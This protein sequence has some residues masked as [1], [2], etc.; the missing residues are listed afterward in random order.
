MDKLRHHIK[1]IAVVIFLPIC[2]VEQA[3]SQKNI[4]VRTHQKISETEGV[5]N[6]TL[7]DIDQFGVSL[8]TIGDLNKDGIVDLIVGANMDDDGGTNFG[9]VWILFMEA[10]GTVKSNQK[11]SD[12]QGNF[13]EGL[14][15][16]DLFGS[17]VS[18][19]GDL[20]GDSITDIA[21]SVLK[22][23]DGGT[24]RGAVFILFLN[25]DGTVKSY[26]KISS[27]QGG[28]AGDLGDEDFFGSSLTKIADLNGDTIPDLVVGARG[29]DDGATDQGGL[30]ILYL[31][32]NG[33]VKNHSKISGLKGNFTGTLD[34]D[35]QFGYSVESL[36]DLD[37][38]GVGDIAVGSINND[39][40]GSNR[41]A[42][43]ILFLNSNG[44]VKSHQ[45]IS[46]TT[47]NFTSKLADGDQFGSAITNIGDINGDNI[48]DI[49]VSATLHD[50]TGDN[51]GAVWILLLNTD[52]TVKED[53]EISSSQGNFV[54]N[55][56]SEDKFGSSLTPLGDLDNDGL[57]DMA[58]GCFHDDD[59]GLDK[60]AIYLLFLRDS[61]ICNTTASFIESAN[62]ICQGQTVDFT[63]TSFADSYIWQ[64]ND[65][66]FSNET[67]IAKTFNSTGIYIIK[68]I[69][70]KE[71]CLDTTEITI[72]VQTNPVSLFNI[73]DS[74]YCTTSPITLNS[75]STNNSNITWLID[76]VNIADT[77]DT[78][79]T[80]SNSGNYTISLI[81]G[82][83]ACSDTSEKSITIIESAVSSF[84]II[85]T[86]VC[87]DEIISISNNSSGSSNYQWFINN[88]KVSDSLNPKISNADS[89]LY[90]IQLISSNS[91]CADTSNKDISI[92]QS[93]NITVSN[94]S[95]ICI[96]DLVALIASGATSYSWSPS[97][98][99]PLPDSAIT[100][101]YPDTTTRYQVIL[102]RGECSSDTQYVTITVDNYPDFDLGE[103]IEGLGGEEI[104]LSASDG[105]T[106]I[107]SPTNYLNDPNIANPIA[108]PLAPITYTVSVTNQTGCTT[109]DSIFIDIKTD[110]FI[111]NFFSPNEDGENDNFKIYGSGISEIELQ[112]FNRLGQMV[113][114]TTD[115]NE[116]QNNGWNGSYNGT[117]QPD[118]VYI[119]KIY[120]T[121]Y[122]ETELSYQRKNV[123][124]FTLLR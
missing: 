82:I 34:A 24:D 107:W 115:I 5:F 39:D 98:N 25:Q 6:G 83:S 77:S 28:F 85:D 73:S 54:G 29:D 87:T 99:L 53:F 50:D 10:D 59:G 100:G 116:A 96:G 33:T 106:Y 112:I 7:D 88:T 71:G 32:T 105:E 43:W 30:W 70:E 121:F 124:T 123:G 55:L 113:F 65:S 9:A 67:S 47:G 111:P 79:I 12:I 101:A 45:K 38:D 40:G 91:A 89:G 78:V 48:T 119:W 114:I 19:L 18:N 57:L 31:D 117:Q 120:G 61:I 68:L 23:D 63:N 58:V 26:K 44:T 80:I 103:D 76:N 37:N 13:N 1:L 36:G 81:A 14:N 52:G 2:L 16:N 60:G 74:V 109:I 92:L 11:I 21:V 102:G 27:T 72:T 51:T 86:I 46:D 15:A 108:T 110:I 42:V 3:F 84:T 20:N 69:A 97:E 95:A 49:A 22:D 4:Q 118:G 41:G 75:Q 8:D 66:T 17:A 64:E 56:E 104:I 93:P 35:D 62:D 94:D 122:N 90:E